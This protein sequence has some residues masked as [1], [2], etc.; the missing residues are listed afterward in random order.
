MFKQAKK[1]YRQEQL[2]QISLLI[3]VIYGDENLIKEILE[4]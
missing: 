1:R 2:K 3:G 4:D